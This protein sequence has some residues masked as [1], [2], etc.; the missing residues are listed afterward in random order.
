MGKIRKKESGKRN[1]KNIW[2][3]KNLQKEVHAFG[4]DFRWQTYLLTFICVLLLIGAVGIFFRLQSNYIVIISLLVLVM[5]PV[6]IVDMYK[7][8]YEQK[9]FA[10]VTDYMEQVLYGFRKNRKVLLALKECKDAMPEGMMKRTVVEAIEY[11]ER[12]KAQTEKGALSEALDLIESAYQCEKIHTVHEL[13]ISA[14]ERGGNAER[15]IELL[16]DNIDIWKRQIYM[17][18]SNKKKSHM[19]NVF[20]IVVASLLCGLTMYI[21]NIV[22]GMVY[23]GTDVSVFNMTAVQ[24]SSF[25]FVLM[26]L[27]T[28]YKSTKKLTDNW[29]EVDRSQEK[30]ILRSYQYVKNYDEKKE[31]NKSIL[32]ALPFLIVSVPC[33]IWLSKAGSIICILI[34][35]FMLVQHRFSYNMSMKEVEKALYMAFPQW[36][37]DIALLLQTSNVQVSIAESIP[38]AET[39]LLEE[40]QEL[41]RRVDERPGDVQ[42]YTEFCK[43]FNIPEMVSCMKMLYSISESGTGNADTQIENLMKHIHQ[44]QKIEADLRNENIAFNMK[45][46]FFVPVASTSIKLLVD[47]AVGTL[48]IFQLFSQAF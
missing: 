33:Y 37:M 34:A 10:D 45:M 3:P 44:F 16:L 30:T 11:L 31:R 1:W 18:Q 8:M 6:L 43:E 47:M 25:V 38:K 48:L 40:L 2:N 41:K 7:R 20:S 9:R 32:M 28:F 36:M 35:V 19:D 4:Y 5:L 21:M 46:I 39:V 24:V 27:W 14:E 22:K 26:C 17:L 15:S 42:S 13:L 23:V 29:L 12:G